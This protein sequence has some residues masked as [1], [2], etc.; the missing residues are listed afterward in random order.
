L[1]IQ[2]HKTYEILNCITNNCIDIL[3]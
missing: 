1:R 3:G 2:Q